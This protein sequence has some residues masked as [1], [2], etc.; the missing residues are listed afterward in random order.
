LNTNFTEELK[1]P[2]HSIE[3]EQS[4]IGALLIDS[5]ELKALNLIPDDF[6]RE[7]HRLIMSVIL[8]LNEKPIDIVSVAEELKNINKLDFVGGISYLARLADGVPNAANVSYYARL[9]K[10]NS[11]S[12]QMIVKGEQISDFAGRLE[13]EKARKTANEIVLLNENVDDKPFSDTFNSE[14]FER[15]SKSKR[16]FSNDLHT[17]TFYLPFMRGENIYIAG[18]TSTGKTQLALN[19]A[20]SFLD[21]GASVGYI[22]M[23]LGREQLLIR[24]LNWEMGNEQIRLSDIDIRKKEWWDLGMNLVKQDKFKNFYFTE[25]FNRLDDIVAWIEIHKFDV[26]FVDYI[27]LMK[28]GTGRNRVE[29]LGDIAKEFRRL[30]KKRCMIILS[31]F[32][33]QKDEDEETIDLSRIRDS[34]E[35]EQTAT[36][37]ILIRRD[38][39]EA[40]Q[41]YYAIAKNQTYGSLSFWKRIDLNFNGAFK[42]VND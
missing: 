33:R 9:V 6:Y 14:D 31:Q 15:L 29:E 10:T 13:F 8:K 21:R 12:R 30:S 25:D 11:I 24:L 27:Q 3:A 18:K 4:V 20:L 40:S 1:V 22:S 38:K 2:P 41:F 37:V 28:S 32:N 17:L 39:K 35:I 16:F 5:K 26:V 19:L 36:G 23:E 7:E 42:E 34:G